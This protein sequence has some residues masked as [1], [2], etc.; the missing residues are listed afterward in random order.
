MRV[1]SFLANPTLYTLNIS[2]SSGNCTPG[3]PGGLLLYFR[4]LARETNV[5]FELPASPSGSKVIGRDLFVT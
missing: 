5:T 2:I 4:G 1:F 3:F